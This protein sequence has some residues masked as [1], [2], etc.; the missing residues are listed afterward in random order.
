MKKILHIVPTPFFASRG[1]HMR[2]LGE[3]RAL[4]RRGYESVV[5]TYHNGEEVENLAIKR[6]IRI[7]WYN[8]LEAGP[9]L[10]KYYLDVLLFFKTLM[11]VRKEKPDLIHGHLHEGVFI[12]HLVRKVLFSK[13]P[14]VFDV[15]GSLTKELDTFNYF[16]KFNFMRRFFS[17]AE[18]YIC[19]MAD[20][21]I[22]SSNSNAELVKGMG[23]D[24]SK[25][26]PVIDGVH[27]DFFNVEV[28]DKFKENLGI[29][30]DKK[31]VIYT[32]ALL[33][34]KGL[35]YL[36][37]V[38]PL[39]LNKMPEVYF[40]IIGYPVEESK[41]AIEEKGLLDRVKFVGM[42]DYFELPKYLHIS[43]VALDPKEDKAGESSGKIINYMGAGL[44]VVC[45]DSLNNRNFL[46][47]SGIYAQNASAE[48]LA[49]KIELVLENESLAK[50]KG[51]GAKARVEKVYSWDAS[52]EKIITAYNSLLPEI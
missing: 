27:T 32:G 12:G 28:D 26:E 44:P 34:A 19:S 2:I 1:C 13:I 52:I 31:V 11:V 20:F 5:V 10:H 14:L 15:Q 16:Q 45:F 18:H 24:E 6:T 42:V 49:A 25:V 36:L 48:D 22:C 37:E 8:K 46:S 38:I 39:V 47:D 40:L 21:F 35:N 23:F 51:K 29:P 50:E 43:D 41:K 17:W 30:A 9:S 7:P 33:K 3:I 4:Q